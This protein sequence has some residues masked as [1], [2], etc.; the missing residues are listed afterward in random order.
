MSGGANGARIR[1]APQKD[2]EANKPKQ[3]A[4]VLEVLG[5]ISSSHGASIADAIILA[6]NVGIE[7]AS[8]IEV[9]FIP[10]RGDASID[11]TDVESFDVLEP[12]A[13]GFRNYLKTELSISPEEM[14]LDKAHLL[15]LT[16]PEMAVLVGGL[17]SMGISATGQG[18]W[19][20]DGMLTNEWFRI[21]LDMGV[22]WKE[23]GPNAYEATDRI[24]GMALR[25][26]T[27]SDLVF[28]SNSELRAIAE[29]YAQNDNKDKFKLDFVKAWN[30]VMTADLV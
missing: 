27:R 16:A 26:A 17:R 20:S 11:Q 15:G 24:S 13:D 19:N 21:L 23:T 8:G 4:R 25:T 7:M 9:P 29:V 3:L 12:I 5:K 2:W 30:K 10:G 18:I 28:G 1:L 22:T 14:L 6:G